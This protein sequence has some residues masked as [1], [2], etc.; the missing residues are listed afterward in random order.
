MKLLVR[1][2]MEHRSLWKIGAWLIIPVGLAVPVALAPPLLERQLIDQAFIGQRLDLLLPI[3]VLYGGV[4]V[5]A[6]V[7]QVINAW[8]RNYLT[9]RVSIALRTRLFAQHARLSVAFSTQEHSGRIMAL[10]ANDVP[11]VTGLF[12]TILVSGVG[13]A[14]GIAISVPVM[15][16]LN[17]QL[18]VAAALVP[19]AVAALAR[20]ITRPLR[21]AARR[22]QE[23]SADLTQELQE[24]LAGVREVVAFGRERRQEG[25]FMAILTEALRLRLRVTTLEA[26][27]MAGQMTFGLA[28]TLVILG[29][30]GFLVIQGQT[31][32]GTL[33][34]MQTIVNLLYHPARELASLTTTVQRALASAERIYAFLDEVPRV[35]DRPVKSLSQPVRGEITFEDVEFGYQAE[36]PVLRGIAFSTQP[37]EVIA[38]VGPSGAGKTTIASLIAR[39]YDPDRGRVLLDGVD[40]RELPLADVRGLTGIVFQNTFLFSGTI[41]DNIAFGRD[42][43]TE[44]QVVAAAHAANAWEFISRMPRGLDTEVGER[45]V[46]LSEGQRQ[47]IAIARAL[48]RD[49]RILILD[50]PTSALDARTEHLL[51][52]AF[53]NLMRG[54][55]TFVIA[56][57]LST[58]QQA[59][60]ILVLDRGRIV[61][62]GSHLELLRRDGLYRELYELQFAAGKQ[63]SDA[64]SD[65]AIASPVPSLV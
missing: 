29:Y 30:G 11:A 27:F 50:E 59:D 35:Q 64:V 21:P 46:R 57:R 17:W 54:R 39:F 10:F 53:E 58:V 8:L 22:V 37:G 47:R 28:I 7:L 63:A 16:G 4:W 38:L 9:E 45:G 55:T 36:Q 25:R 20:L 65:T 3:L 48:L 12:S 40:L 62:Q 44:Q 13:S 1:Y 6:I 34:A 2:L 19:P 43:A 14:L 23:K 15:V 31:T 24:N 52:S 5:F 42:G 41:R 49:P 32:I 33:V 51:Q 60:R 26:G 61:E 56:H 18:A